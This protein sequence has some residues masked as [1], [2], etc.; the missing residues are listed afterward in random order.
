MFVEAPAVFLAARSFLPEGQ[1]RQGGI[2]HLHRVTGEDVETRTGLR[3]KHHVNGA[4]YV[5]YNI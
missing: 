4:W 2:D 3:P 1:R 5:V